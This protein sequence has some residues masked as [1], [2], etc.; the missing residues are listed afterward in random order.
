M[1]QYAVERVIQWLAIRFPGVSKQIEHLD[2]VQDD[3]EMV[4]AEMLFKSC[5]S[6]VNENRAI[7]KH[8]K[9]KVVEQKVRVNWKMSSRIGRGTRWTQYEHKRFIEGVQLY[10]K[11]WSK[12]QKYVGTRTRLQVNA[13][14]FSLSKNKKHP[15][16]EVFRNLMSTR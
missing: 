11:D 13:R 6:K 14:A 12:I 1:P 5:Y 9:S 4:P 3:D 2:P 15:D 7:K 8:V 16:Y 10:G